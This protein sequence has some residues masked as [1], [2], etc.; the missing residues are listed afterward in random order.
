[1]TILNF[2]LLWKTTICV[3]FTETWLTNDEKI[4]LPLFWDDHFVRPKKLKYGRNSGGISVFV[5][6]HMRPGIKVVSKAEGFFWLKLDKQFFGLDNHLFFCVCYIPPQNS[7]SLASVKVDYFKE[8]SQD[9]AKFSNDGDI[10]LTGDLNSR[11]G[12][13]PTVTNKCFGDLDNLL[14]SDSRIIADIPNRASCDSIQNQYGRNL[15][16]LCYNFNMHIANGRTPGDRLGNF[17]CFTPRG[18]YC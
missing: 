3:F 9:I 8:L 5:K 16:K 14:P 11:V 12:H 2:L 17:T 13:T 10:I 1:M 4:N 6:Q 18:Q 15:K 7:V